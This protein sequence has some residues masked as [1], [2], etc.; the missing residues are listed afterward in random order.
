MPSSGSTHA[1]ADLAV[2][3]GVEVAEHVAEVV[4]EAGDLE[5]AVVGRDALE[6]VGALQ[7]VGED[8]DRVAELAERVEHAVARREALDDL[9][10]R[11]S[12]G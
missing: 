5:L 2:V 6:L 11:A 10:D 3:D 12:R 4:H 8:V 7:R 9:V 1:R